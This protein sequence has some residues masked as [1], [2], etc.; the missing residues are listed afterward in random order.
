ML[1]HSWNWIKHKWENEVLSSAHQRLMNSSDLNAFCTLL[2]SDSTPAQCIALEHYTRAEMDTRWG[3]ENPYASVIEEI[4]ECAR[5]QLE[6]PPLPSGANYLSAWGVLFHLATVEDGDP[7]AKSLMHVRNHRVLF[8]GVLAA[9]AVF[10]RFDKKSEPATQKLIGVLETMIFDDRYP[11][12]L[13]KEALSVFSDSYTKSSRIMELIF[14]ASLLTETIIQ[15]ESV[16]LL[17]FD[18]KTHRHRVQKIVS[19]W[20]SEMVK[21]NYRAQEVLEWLEENDD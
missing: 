11:V 3:V 7:I 6:S 9:S 8:S 1:F 2:R 5:M 21:T 20:D 19:T 13:R 14:K 4:Y 17:A 10:Q 18:L 16:R 15:I 12:E